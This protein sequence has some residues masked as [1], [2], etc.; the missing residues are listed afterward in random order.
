MLFNELSKLH[1]YLDH[2]CFSLYRKIDEE[3]V[4]QL[5]LIDEATLQHEAIKRIFDDALFTVYSSDTFENSQKKYR[6]ILQFDSKSIDVY[7]RVPE[8]S[9][10]EY[11]SL[12]ES[13]IYETL[14]YI[15]ECVQ[16]LTLQEEVYERH[17]PVLLKQAGKRLLQGILKNENAVSP[18]EKFSKISSLSYERSFSQGKIL[19][20][21]TQAAHALATQHILRPLVQFES[22]IPLSSTR[23]IRKILE[24]S[25]SDV[26]LLSDG[27]F[28]YSTVEFRPIQDTTHHFF[29][30]EF[31]AYSAWQ[32]TYNNN[33][34]M[35]VTHEEIQLPKPKVSF[36]SFSNEFKKVYPEIEGKRLLNLYRLILE[37]TKQTKGTIFAISKNARS[38]SNRLKNQGFLIESLTLTPSMVRSITSI[39]G[40]VLMDLDGVCHGIGVILDGI[41]TDK[42]DP[43]RGARYNSAIR[44]V[45]TISKNPNYA[46]CFAVVISE[47]GDVD[48]ILQSL[49]D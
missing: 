47:D 9:E 8:A 4:P 12:L 30:I 14:A 49:L 23:H 43:S 37:G 11:R 46:N 22:K 42:G 41:A 15:N 13:I 44:Y 18:F 34:L 38:E 10:L 28:L 39:D 21:N 20:L 35:Q 32:L 16:G 19:L 26:Y 31:S 45:E 3:M 25:R 17:I 6:F 36:F 33:K 48:M 5:H 40:A 24:L 2:Y 29:T 1:N 7:Y 27:E